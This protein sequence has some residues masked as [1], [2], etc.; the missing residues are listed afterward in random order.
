MAPSLA[1]PSIF[2]VSALELDSGYTVHLLTLICSVDFGGWETSGKPTRA[3]W[4]GRLVW[5]GAGLCGGLRLVATVLATG[6][7]LLQSP[8]TCHLKGPFLPEVTSHSWEYGHAHADS[9][10]GEPCFAR[11]LL[12]AGCGLVQG[13]GLSLVLQV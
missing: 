5:Y 10:L 4:E 9:L 6:L 7:L 12:P 8:C 11:P 13:L 3:P 1:C 2:P